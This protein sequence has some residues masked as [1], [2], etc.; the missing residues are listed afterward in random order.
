MMHVHWRILY[1]TFV[2]SYSVVDF[3]ATNSDVFKLC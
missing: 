2:M 1:F 3:A